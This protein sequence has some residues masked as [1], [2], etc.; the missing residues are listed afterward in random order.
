MKLRIRRECRM[1]AFLSR[2]WREFRGA[3]SDDQ[4]VED[5]RQAAARKPA[6]GT[7]CSRK[8]TPEAK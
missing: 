7:G 1:L 5:L 2:I 3:Y 4:F 8:F 6:N